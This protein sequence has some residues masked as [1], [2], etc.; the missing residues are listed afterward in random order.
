MSSFSQLTIGGRRGISP[1][2]VEVDTKDV[3]Q[4]GAA[5]EP[6]SPQLDLIRTSLEDTGCAKRGGHQTSS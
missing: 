2:D 1:H 5:A 6:P 4:I 3:A